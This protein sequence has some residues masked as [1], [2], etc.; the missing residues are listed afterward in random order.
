MPLLTTRAAL[1][2]SGFNSVAKRLAVD[3][4]VVGGGGGGKSPPGNDTV[5]GG[6]GG[7]QA[8][9]LVYSLTRGDY[10]AYV[11][12]G[13]TSLGGPTS[14]DESSFGSFSAGIS[15]ARA[16]GGVRAADFPSS[17]TD[18]GNG[19]SGSLGAAGNQSGLSY[20][21]GGGG[22][23]SNGFS[24][25]FFTGPFGFGWYGGTPGPGYVWIDGNR[26]GQG[27]GGG[28]MSQ[29]DLVYGG[30]IGGAGEP[31]G[32]SIARL[33]GLAVPAVAPIDGTGFGGT[34]G[35]QFSPTTLN[36][37][38]GADGCVIVSYAGSTAVASGG[39]IVIAGGRVYHKF[40]TPGTFTFTY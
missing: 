1:S 21:G 11:G 2:S 28:A 20:A 37:T 13:G 32:A 27:G 3:I 18:G 7:G 35:A 36:G 26:Y 23:I 14:G 15:Y 10:Y 19:G 9:N 22:G 16:L 29:G 24:G 4:L 6:G 33:S 17:F 12:N 34:G 31:R 25:A 40:T 30:G 39:T 5:G 8:V 38:D